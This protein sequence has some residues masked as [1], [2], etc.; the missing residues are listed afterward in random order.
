MSERAGFIKERLNL[1]SDI[2]KLPDGGISK[3]K[4]RDLNIYRGQSGICRDDS[5]ICISLLN[6]G[7][8]YPDDIFDGGILYHYPD[9]KRKGHDINEIN[10]VKE[11]AS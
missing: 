10:S 5:G 4:I 7:K 1:W 8:H 2:Q 6:T 11:C 9:T 3:S